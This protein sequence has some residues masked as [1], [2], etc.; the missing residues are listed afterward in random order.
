VALDI[1]QCRSAGRARV[2]AALA[3]AAAPAVPDRA[4]VAR[5]FVEAVLWLARTGSPWRD[6]PAE[7]MNGRSAWRRLQRWT[8][9]GIWDR[10]VV[11]RHLISRRHE[12]YHGNTEE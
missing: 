8:D 1:A 9:A 4:T 3:R 10:V 7:L 6:L 11:A 2:N 12:R 5:R